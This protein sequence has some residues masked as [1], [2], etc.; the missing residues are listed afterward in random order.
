MIRKRSQRSLLALLLASVALLATATGASAAIAGAGSTIAGAVM[1]NWTNGFLIREGITVTYSSSGV[2]AGLQKL[3]SH[4]VE[5]AAVDGPLS[6][7]QAAQCV[8]CAQIPWLLTG[9]D[10]AYR[11]KGVNK[12]DLSGKVLTGIFTG[13]ITHWNDPKIVALNPKAKLPASTITVV[14]PAEASGETSA[15]TNYL[16]KT[17]PAWKKSVG[18]VATVRLPVGTAAKADSGVGGIVASTPGSIGYVSAPYAFATSLR[19]ASIENAAGEDIAPTIES[20]GAAGATAKELPASG[21][22]NVTYPP[23]T[24]KGAYPLAMFGYAVVPH[25]APQKGF[26]EQFLNYAV[27][28]GSSFGS[29]FGIAPLPKALKGAVRTAVAGL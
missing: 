1:P 9:V 14:Y 6:P 16:S 15:F 11:L 26:I 8:E 17:S 23:K 20:F 21:V 28:P 25:T 5:F 2:E 24:A 27:G 18:T 10:V 13:K 3:A 22:V 7:E 19:T 4:T 12:L 29:V